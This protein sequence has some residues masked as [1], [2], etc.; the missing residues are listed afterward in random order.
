M[1]MYIFVNNDLGMDKGKIAAQ[2]CHGVQLMMEAILVHGQF[3]SDYQ[4]WR[5]SGMAK[6]VLKANTEQ[7]RQ[8]SERED[9]VYVVDAGLTQIP[10]GSLTVVVLPPSEDPHVSDLAKYKLL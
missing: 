8:L 7:I 9:A 2:A 6:V 10:A 1:R 4:Q 5:Q 3:K